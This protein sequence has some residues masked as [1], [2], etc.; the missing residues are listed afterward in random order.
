MRHFTFILFI[1]FFISCGGPK[2]SWDDARVILIS[3]DGLG[4]DVLNHPNIEK[5]IPNLFR[6]MEMGEF[7]TDVQTVFPSLTYPAHTSMITGVLPEKHGIIN[8]RPF[9]PDKI[10]VDWYWYADSIKVP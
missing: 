3:I 1:L 2:G 5:D 6:L 4:G 9:N 8:N 10:F 7:C